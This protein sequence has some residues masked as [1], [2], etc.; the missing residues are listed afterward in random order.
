[1]PLRRGKKGLKLFN[2]FK[3]WKRL[4]EAEGKLEVAR[5]VIADLKEQI[6]TL[7]AA[8]AEF[9]DAWYGSPKATGRATTTERPVTTPPLTASAR[10]ARD[11]QRLAEQA[12]NEDFLSGGR[13]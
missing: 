7:E 5:D 6:A 10:T 13:Q 2:F 9:A 4:A 8:K 1:M 12:L 11:Y 3:L